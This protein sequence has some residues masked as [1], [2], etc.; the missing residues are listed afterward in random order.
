MKNNIISSEYKGIKYSITEETVSDLKQ[1]YNVD[2]IQEIERGI[3]LHLRNI[4]INVNINN[5]TAVVLLTKN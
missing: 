2:A 4:N 3:E 1:Y 5:D